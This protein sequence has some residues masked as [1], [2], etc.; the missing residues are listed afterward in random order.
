M[1]SLTFRLLEVFQEVVD[2]GSVT[3]ASN[4]LALSQPTVSLQLKKLS[5]I[6]GLPLLEHFNGKVR[7][8]EAGEAVYRCAQVV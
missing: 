1:N 2:G 8:T 5:T 4:A 6:V 3:A 7:M